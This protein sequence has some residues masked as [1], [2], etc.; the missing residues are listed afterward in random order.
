VSL[1]NL[2]RTVLDVV[3][4]DTAGIPGFSLGRFWRAMNPV[5]ELQDEPVLSELTPAPRV[6]RTNPIALG[7]MRS[8]VHGQWHYIVNGKWETELFDYQIDPFEVRNLSGAPEGSGKAI[9]T[10]R[11][12]IEMLDQAFPREPAPAP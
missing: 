5:A 6:P 2:A 9:S 8:M 3:G 12:R 7:E 1:R 11:R 4:Q 10:M